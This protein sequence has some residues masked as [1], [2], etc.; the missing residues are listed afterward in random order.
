MSLVTLQLVIHLTT[1]LNH[2][3]Y[4]FFVHCIRLRLDFSHR[5]NRVKI[6]TLSN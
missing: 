2:D 4:N 6:K 3:L 5:K 1:I